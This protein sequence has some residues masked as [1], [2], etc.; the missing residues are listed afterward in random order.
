MGSLFGRRP[1]GRSVFLGD[2]PVRQLARFCA[3]LSIFGALA[4][5]TSNAL[6][7]GGGEIKVGDKA[8]AFEGV[9]DQGKSWKSTDVVGKKIVVVYFY[10]ADF[11]GGCTAQACGFRDDAKPLDDKGVVVVGVSGDSVKNHA[12]FKKEYML[13]FTLLSDEKGTVASKFGVPFSA[14]QGKANFKGQTIVREGTANRWTVIIG[15]DGK[16]A[17]RYSVSDAKGDSKK[18]LEAVEKLQK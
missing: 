18:V 4:M 9:D 14:K 11:T 1:P 3:A 5:L 16:V 6:S 2:T 7:A 10:P 15:K 17:A 8:P 12:D 13:N